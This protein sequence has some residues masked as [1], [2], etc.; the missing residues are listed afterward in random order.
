MTIA[1]L[2]GHAVLAVGGYIKIMMTEPARRDAPGHAP[3]TDRKANCYDNYYNE[4]SSF[5]LS[6]NQ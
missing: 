5:S 4:K 3:G 2:T 6:D 1:R